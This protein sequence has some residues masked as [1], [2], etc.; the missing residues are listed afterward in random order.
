MNNLQLL[1]YIFI[2]AITA[3]IAF[4]IH[5]YVLKQLELPAY[6]NKIILSYILNT[7][8]AIGILLALYF[9]RHKFKQQLGFLFMVGSFLKFTCFFIF[10]YPSF[11]ADGDIS[12]LEFASF[13]VPYATCLF[14]ETL[15]GIKLLNSLD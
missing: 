13:F 11:R 5:T 8:L 4:F 2:I 10:F 3:V 12:N 1:K 7:I 14:T 6:G 9:F 15:G